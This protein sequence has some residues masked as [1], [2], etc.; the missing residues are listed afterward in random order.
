MCDDA[1]LDEHAPRISVVDPADLEPIERIPGLLVRTPFHVGGRRLELLEIEGRTGWHRRGSRVHGWV[2]AGTG[3]LEYGPDEARVTISAGDFLRLSP[4]VVHRY[5][6]EEPLSVLAVV[7]REVVPAD[8]PTPA[9]EVV[10]PEVADEDDLVPAVESPNL[11]RETPFPDGETLMLRV[12]ADGGV[13]AGWHHHGENV[14]FGYDVDGPSET[15]YGPGGG[16]VAR[17]EAGECFHVPPGLV[18][19]DTNPG[20]ETHSAIVWLCGGEPWVVNVDGPV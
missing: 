3:R 5:A 14:Y 7:E 6:A 1:T 15:E 19:R 20:T 8:P 17:I 9:D 11:V 12:R 4:D 10:E 2:R 18:H 16:E 13:A